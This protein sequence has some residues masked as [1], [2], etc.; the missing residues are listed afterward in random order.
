[1]DNLPIAHTVDRSATGAPG[2]FHRRASMGP[3]DEH[4]ITDYG[5]KKEMKRIKLLNNY[6][7]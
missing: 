6:F 1:M 5:A 4:S 7:E 3:P 2:S